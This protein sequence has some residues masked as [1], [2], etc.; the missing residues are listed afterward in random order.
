MIDTLMPLN[1]QARYPKD[2]ELLLK[3]LD[4]KKCKE[5]FKK[6][7]ELYEWIRKLLKR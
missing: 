4:Y 2:K 3:K 6:T 1:I 5:I 7:R